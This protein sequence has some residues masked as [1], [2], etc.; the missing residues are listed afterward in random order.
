[1]LLDVT[2]ASVAAASKTAVNM[3]TAQY[4]KA[5]PCMRINALEPVTPPPISMGTRAT[6]T[7]EQRAEIIVQMTQ[8]GPDGPT[9]GYF[10]G[11]GVPW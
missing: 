5:F 6:Q 8:V 11:E 1:V 7:V 9:G 4:A 10:D 3:I 2:D